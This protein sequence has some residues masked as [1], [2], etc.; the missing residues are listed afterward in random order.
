M[1]TV[2]ACSVIALIIVLASFTY[3]PPIHFLG[4]SVPMHRGTSWQ[5]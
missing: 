4:E 5:R 3:R 1:K 2:I